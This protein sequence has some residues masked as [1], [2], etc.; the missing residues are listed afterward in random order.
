MAGERLTFGIMLGGLVAAGAGIGA[1]VAL[2][3]GGLP[4]KEP[5]HLDN[6]PTLPPLEQTENPYA[7]FQIGEFNLQDRKGRPVTQAV[8]DGEVTFLSFFFASCPGPCPI[9]SAK[10]KELQDATAGTGVR[11]LSISVDGL[12]DTPEVIGNYADGYGADPD[13]WVF[14]TGHP[15]IVELL[16]SESLDYRVRR[17]AGDPIRA[18]DGS[19]IANIL[20]PTR[21]MLIGPDRRLL[22][23]PVS[24]T[25]AEGVNELLAIALRAAPGE[26]G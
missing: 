7:E 22:G 25:D 14:L 4:N 15:Q 19:T 26:P 3:S 13:R 11:L 1:L 12:R 9:I 6:A 8:L 23:P 18:V 10:M 20:H 21:I 5:V 2:F 16:L 17:Q 24:A